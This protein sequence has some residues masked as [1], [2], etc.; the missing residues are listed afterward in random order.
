MK[1]RLVDILYWASLIALLITVA[2]SAFN[3]SIVAEEPQTSPY[4]YFTPLGEYSRSDY[5]PL[6]E[7]WAAFTK[8]GTV[9]RLHAKHGIE[10]LFS[11][12]LP[13]KIPS[14][15]TGETEIVMAYT[16]YEEDS[17]RALDDWVNIEE[18]NITEDGF[19]EIVFHITTPYDIPSDHYEF[20][21]LTYGLEQQTGTTILE[22]EVDDEDTTAIAS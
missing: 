19:V 17:S 15:T 9:Y 8:Y 10:F 18:V 2:M 5:G 6:G 14:I 21:A 4:D 11:V 16:P 13:K 22:I 3:D 12:T 1:K 20:W 7:D